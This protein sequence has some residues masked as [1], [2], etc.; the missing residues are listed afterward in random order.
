MTA[1]IFKKNQ[2]VILLLAL[3][4][5]F[6][7]TVN[8]LSV[9]ILIAAALFLWLLV[10]NFEAATLLLMFFLPFQFALNLSA[11]FDVASGRVLILLFFALWLL[12]SLKNKKLEV[13]F[14]LQTLLLGLFLLLATTSALHAFDMDRALRKLLVLL[15][16]FP[17]YFVLTSFA[18]RRV[19]LLRALRYCLYAGA[20]LA[21][22]GLVQC[23]AQFVWGIDPLMAFSAGIAPFFYGQT[24][25]AEVVSNPSWLVN[26]G[27]VT[28]LRAFAIFPDPHAFSF[29]LG[30]ILPLAFV[31]LLLGKKETDTFV[32]GRKTLLLIFILLL[33]AE[34]LTFS[35]G[36]YSGMLSSF[37]VMLILLRNRF[38]SGQKRLLLGS[39]VAAFVLFCTF[40]GAIATR[41]LSSF[42]PAEGSNAE[43]LKNWTQGWNIF[44][45]HFLGG[46]GLG[47]YSLYLDPTLA[48]RAPVYAHN[49]YLDL[50]AEMGVFAL[51]VW[52]LLVG[53]T[54]W[55]LY[56]ASKTTADRTL[57]FLS[58]GFIGSLTWYSIHCFFDDSFFAPNILSVL[59]V[60]LSLSVL[61]IQEVKLKE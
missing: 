56:R 33:L 38:T 18:D 43:R 51:L 37:I 24:A 1:E 3:A 42:D 16:V 45:S 31:L 49:L 29:Y 59:V 10:E 40:A 35:R 36:G 6:M 61:L 25:A 17:L 30:L 15:S 22:F 27:G 44:S 50:G 34:L 32:L 13:D 7:I 2:L 48:Y 54:I 12:R 58:L 60:I 9:L 46:V 57:S 39:L 20:L 55:E 8:N 47:N 5:G 4:A 52:V 53:V 11:D 14:S 28:L 26:V 19:F 41:F 23:A 21:A